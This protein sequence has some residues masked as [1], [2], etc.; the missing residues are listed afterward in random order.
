MQKNKIIITDILKISNKFN[1]SFSDEIYNKLFIEQ[2]PGYMSS[3]WSYKDIPC[4]NRILIIVQDG[5]C[6]DNML[7]FLEMYLKEYNMKNNSDVKVSA[8][9]D[10]T[11]ADKLTLGLNLSISI[12]KEP[13]LRFCDDTSPTLLKFSEHQPYHIYSEPL[14]TEKLRPN[15]DLSTAGNSKFSNLTVN[16]QQIENSKSDYVLHDSKDDSTSPTI[17]LH[18]I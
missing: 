9:V 6:F 12:P 8:C 16:T 2:F 13:T 4:F 18:E 11:K 5:Y 7:Q 10:L 1:Q 14:P 15:S 3:M 17:I